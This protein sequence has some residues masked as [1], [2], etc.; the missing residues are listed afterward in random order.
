MNHLTQLGTRRL[1]LTEDYCTTWHQMYPTGPCPYHQDCPRDLSLPVRI[2]TAY[3]IR[4]TLRGMQG[5]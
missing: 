4:A 1:P 5:M 3:A 2:A